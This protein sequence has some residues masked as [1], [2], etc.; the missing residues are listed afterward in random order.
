MLTVD[1][2]RCARNRRLPEKLR[3]KSLS[4]TAVGK[5]GTWR[6]RG[7]QDSGKIQSLIFTQK[8]KVNKTMDGKVTE[9]FT[10]YQFQPH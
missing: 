9:M 5:T 7:K 6:G 1:A 3:K 4:A 8:K 2:E 10:D